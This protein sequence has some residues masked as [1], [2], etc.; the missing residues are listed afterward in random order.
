MLL[1]RN[2][3]FAIGIMSGC[4]AAFFL[5]T[6]TQIADLAGPLPSPSAEKGVDDVQP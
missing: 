4:T 6:R 5:A 1:A 2:P 3:W